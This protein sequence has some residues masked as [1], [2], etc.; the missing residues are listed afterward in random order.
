MLYFYENSNEISI[1]L[2]KYLINFGDYSFQ[3][4]ISETSKVD[5]KGDLENPQKKSTQLSNNII[6]IDEEEK[7][8]YLLTK[9]KRL[10]NKFNS[11]DYF[12]FTSP[13]HF[14]LS[15][16]HQDIPFIVIFKFNGINWK[17]S[18]IILNYEDLINLSKPFSR[19]S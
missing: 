2:N 16:F 13:I 3:K 6:I 1:Y 9:I 15:V 18:N 10:I 19:P 8:E 12:F 17:I 5:K 11:T 4:Y 14:K 7:K